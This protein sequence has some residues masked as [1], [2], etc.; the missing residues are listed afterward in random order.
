MCG[1]AQRKDIDNEHAQVRKRRAAGG[2]G[3]DDVS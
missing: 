1:L 3:E 2:G